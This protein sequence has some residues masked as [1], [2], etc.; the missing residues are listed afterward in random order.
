MSIEA[1]AQKDLALNADD[2]ENV[3][4]G[5]KKKK[6]AP[7]KT[8]VHQTAARPANINIQTPVTPTE[9]S[10]DASDDCE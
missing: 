3:V 10:Y 5:K 2:A 9:T 8:V 6:Q 1:D 7:K 4:G